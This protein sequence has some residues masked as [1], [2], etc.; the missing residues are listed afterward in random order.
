MMDNPGEILERR[1]RRKK[2][3]IFGVCA[4]LAGLAPVVMK[5]AANE[6]VVFPVNLGPGWHL[7]FAARIAVFVAL[8]GALSLAARW[9]WVASD[10]VRRS[11]ILSFWAAIGWSLSATFVV[12]ML[13]GRDIPEAERL[14]VA[15]FAP[16]WMGVLFSI[17][18]WLRQGFVWW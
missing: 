16:I 17:A 14:H 1:Y 12:F 8:F 2:L 3:L 18:R 15:F 4:M 5:A 9:N 10:E 7:S 6:N 13:F 11:H